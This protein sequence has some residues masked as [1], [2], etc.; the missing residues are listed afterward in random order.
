MDAWAVLNGTYKLQVLN[1][2][3][4]L[5]VLN[6]TYKLW[7]LNALELWLLNG[8]CKL[9]VLNHTYMLCSAFLISSIRLCLYCNTNSSSRVSSSSRNAWSLAASFSSSNCRGDA[10]NY[11]V[12]GPNQGTETLQQWSRRQHANLHGIY[13]LGSVSL[14]AAFSQPPAPPCA[15]PPAPWNDASPVA[16]LWTPSGRQ[17]QLMDF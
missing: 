10:L 4:K 6:G 7:L 5:W 16:H 8:T 3:C 15:Q 12:S 11:Q 17:W 14:P 9:Q 13:R 1:G 2:T